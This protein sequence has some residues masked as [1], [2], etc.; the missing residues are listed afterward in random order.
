MT[1]ELVLQ[2]GADAIK[3]MIYL[4]GPML[5]AAMAIGLLVSVFQAV[6]Q[7]NES[8]LTFIPK[9]IAIILVLVVMAPWMIEHLRQ[10]ATDVLTQA[11]ELVR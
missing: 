4:A 10:Y 5:F 6:T 1:E 11:G 8:T 7:I 2:I 3:T 9:M